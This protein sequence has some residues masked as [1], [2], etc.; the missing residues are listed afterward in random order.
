MPVETQYNWPLIWGVLIAVGLY[1][2]YCIYWSVIGYRSA[3]SLSGW[4]IAGRTL[5]AWL[6]MLSASATSF[7]A[8]TYMGHPGTVYAG[9][10]A[11]AFAGLYAITIPFTGALF[12]KR[13]WMLGRRYGFVTPPEQYR[14]IFD[15]YFLGVIIVIVSF[16]YSCFYVAVQLIGSGLLFTVI[17]NGFFPFFFGSVAL[18]LIMLI[19]VGAGG[20][21]TIAWVDVLQYFL[22]FGGITLIGVGVLYG[23]GGWGPF[24]EQAWQLPRYYTNSHSAIHWG[25]NWV[26]DV[27]GL[28]PK[29]QWTGVMMLTYMFALAGIQASPA[30]TMWAYSLRHART[31]AYQIVICIGVVVTATLVLWSVVQGVGAQILAHQNPGEWGTKELVEFIRA[32]GAEG[33]GSDGVVPK[34]MLTYLPL[35][36][37]P[38]AAIGLLAA[39]QST[40]G[41]YISSFAAI[42]S[43]NIIGELFL[44][45]ARGAEAIM[46]RPGTMS[47]NPGNPVHPGNPDGRQAHEPM[48]ISDVFPERSQ[49]TWSRIF[50][51]VLLTASLYVAFQQ[52]DL[53][54]M[55]GGLAVSYGFQLY[56]ALL[57]ICYGF[58]GWP[59]RWTPQGV[60]A[61]LLVGILAVTLTYYW[62]AYRYTLSIHSA[63][64]GIIFNL[65]TILVVSLFTTPSRRHIE[66]QN[67]LDEFYR[68]YDPAYYEPR[69]QAWRKFLWFYIPFW[70][71]MFVGPG[72][73][74][75]NALDRVVF[76][77]P[78]IWTWLILG[79]IT[80]VFLLWAMSFPAQ[81]A[82]APRHTPE[83]VDQA[84]RLSITER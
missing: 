36:L 59:I 79:G 72:I 52:Q 29:P 48:L 61:G 77:L 12:I 54:V 22:T 9:G 68:R 32:A 24:M 10:I 71:I 51:V 45:R 6:F 47:R 66:W 60:N 13:Q 40:A 33:A 16:L 2:A 44:Y 15:S 1:W 43:R 11:Y 19:Y 55:L 27:E 4:G 75:G 49:V 7:S 65:L 34:L 30:F 74:F 69:A 80:G 70:W 57:M 31:V 28:G 18:A 14:T 41:P 8:W 46:G 17:T 76:D 25:W 62:P 67:T 39:A 78:G 53:M 63:G 35:V 37:V 58:R 38:L 82:T 23:L 26:D 83:P 3:K 64:W 81:M 84:A 5:P 21:R 50:C 73:E 56:P 20:L 42:A